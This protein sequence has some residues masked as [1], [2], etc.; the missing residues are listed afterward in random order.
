MVDRVNIIKIAVL[1]SI[2]AML[3]ILIPRQPMNFVFLS[4]LEIFRLSFF[5]L[6]IMTYHLI[7]FVLKPFLHGVITH[8]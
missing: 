2:N 3:E 5:A 4:C 7:L 6:G 8:H 1:R